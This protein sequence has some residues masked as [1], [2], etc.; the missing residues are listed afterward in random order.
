[1]PARNPD[2]HGMV[3]DS[4]PVALLLLDVINHPKFPEGPAPDPCAH[5]SR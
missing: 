2:L 1:M 5:A 4:A 3:P